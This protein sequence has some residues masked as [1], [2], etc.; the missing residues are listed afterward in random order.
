MPTHAGRDGV[1]P[2]MKEAGII[3]AVACISYEAGVT[4]GAVEACSFFLD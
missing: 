4:Q 1:G 3:Q 2:G